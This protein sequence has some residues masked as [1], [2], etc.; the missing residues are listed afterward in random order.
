LN[1]K[2]N[3]N[4]TNLKERSRL[5]S[6]KLSRKQ[7]DSNLNREWKWKKLSEKRELS[8]LD[9]SRRLL[10]LSTRKSLN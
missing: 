3:L 7:L 1:G 8:K 10:E 2:S 5:K 9:L 6:G 4:F